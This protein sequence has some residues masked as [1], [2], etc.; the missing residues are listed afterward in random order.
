[1][2]HLKMHGVAVI[3][4]V[5]K[6]HYNLLVEFCSNFLSE[7]IISGVHILMQTEDYTSLG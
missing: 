7:F 3:T 2:L 6:I 5:T 1:M 4:L